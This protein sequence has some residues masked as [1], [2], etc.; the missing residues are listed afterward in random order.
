M[1][2]RQHQGNFMVDHTIGLRSYLS[3]LRPLCA[4]SSPLPVRFQAASWRGAAIKLE[5][6][7][8]DWKQRAGNTTKR[9]ISQNRRARLDWV[10]FLLCESVTL[11]HA[12][13]W[14]VDNREGALESNFLT[15]TRKNRRPEGNDTFWV[16][17][18]KPERR[19][20][21]TLPHRCYD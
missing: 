6:E 19:I 10:V 8:A 14:A 21:N 11:H 4:S 12:L 18:Q 5:V 1:E 15:P 13:G 17:V 2:C 7:M 16:P 20:A 3:L 9:C